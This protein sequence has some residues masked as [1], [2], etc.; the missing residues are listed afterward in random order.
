MINE[1]VILSK[2]ESFN[3]CMVGAAGFL[4]GINPC[5]FATIVFFISFLAFAGYRK[6]EM[7]LAGSFFT[8]AVFTAYFL[9]GLGIFKFLRSLNIFSYAALVINIIIG[10]LAFVLG[11]LSIVDYFRFKKTHDA[12][13]S[14]LQLSQPIKNKIRSIIG[15]DFRQDQKTGRKAMFKIIW[16]AFTAGFMISILESIC[17][18][19]VYL[20]TI[21]YVL[22]IPGKHMPALLYLLVYNFAFIAPLII[23]FIMGL[24]GATSKDFSK[25]MQCHFGFIKLFTAALFFVL[26]AV[27]IIFK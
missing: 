13:N 16:T 26:G 22:R 12:K 15:A 20:P 9:I 21:A 5:A 11:I 4:D 17:T 2:F 19:Q 18:G 3:I 6:R 25:F 23:V 1:A 10:S 7:I 24:F 14:M 8:I 27:L